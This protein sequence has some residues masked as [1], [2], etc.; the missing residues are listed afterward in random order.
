MSNTIDLTTV[1]GA[2]PWRE[3][4]ETAGRHAGSFTLAFKEV[5]PIHRAFAPMAREQTFDVSEMAIVTAIQ[6]FAF[7]KPLLILPVTLAARFQQGCLIGRSRDLPASPA[8]L[9]GRRVG[10]RAYSQTTGVWVRG[11]LQND[12]AVAPDSIC[13]ITQEGAHVAEYADPPWVERSGSGDKLP[14]MLRRKE[15]DAAIL[16]NDL[17]DDP[18]FAPI[19]EKPSEAAQAWFAKHR[20]VPINHMLVVRQEIASRHPAVVRELWAVIGEA[21]RSLPAAT[22]DMYPLGIEAVRPA[23]DLILSYCEQQSLLP[24]RIASDEIFA[25][26]EPFLA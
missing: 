20:V 21:R 23:L 7:G 8:D 10:V 26:A 1:I 15:I 13:W 24:R 12:F 9:R 25:Q 16:G 3:A 4:L 5:T 11:I 18:D 22:T 17:P 14:D 19:I 2:R 6:A